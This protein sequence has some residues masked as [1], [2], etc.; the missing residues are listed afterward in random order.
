MFD[1]QL[2]SLS[3]LKVSMDVVK[4]WA[5]EIANSYFNAQVLP[6]HTLTKIAQ[7]E[8]LTPHQIEILAAEANKLIHH[9]K[10][11]S[12]TEKYHAADFPMADA[13]EVIKLVQRDGGEEKVAHVFADPKIPDVGPD[14]YEMF[15]IKP[16]PLDKTA[17]VKHQVKTAQAKLELLKQKIDDQVILCKTAEKAA[18]NKFVKEARQCLLE[19]PNSESRVKVL[20]EFYSFIKSAGMEAGRK[21]LAKVAYVLVKEGKIEPGVG[22][23]LMDFFMSK[24]ADEKAPIDIISQNLPARIVNGQHP[25]YI[26]LK[27]IEDNSGNVLRFERDSTLVDDKLRLLK[28]KIRAL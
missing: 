7:I 13:R 8:E 4:E 12:M 16:E 9:H 21:A 15:G 2:P 22:K 14:V 28:Q 24:E 5:G 25:L 10:Y 27:T 11:A 23:K 6:T 3:E 18:E 20:G 19:E 17:S 1:L 26:T